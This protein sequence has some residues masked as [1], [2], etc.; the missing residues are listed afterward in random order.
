MSSKQTDELCL[1]TNHSSPSYAS[2]KR[3]NTPSP[4]VDSSI[5]RKLHLRNT[6][7]YKS[8]DHLDSGNGTDDTLAPADEVQ[9]RR[10]PLQSATDVTEDAAGNGFLVRRRPAGQNYMDRRNSRSAEHIPEKLLD[11]CMVVRSASGSQPRRVDGAG[12]VK[13]RKVSSLLFYF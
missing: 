9:L 13:G 12:M 1:N 11:Q 4:G 3:D 5:R 6:T 8:A 10:R 7:T 2:E